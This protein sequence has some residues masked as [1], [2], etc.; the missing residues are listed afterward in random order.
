MVD[1]GEAGLVDSL[2]SE[3][4][5][6]IVGS[7]A[8]ISESGKRADGDSLST[9][10]RALYDKVFTPLRHVSSDIHKL[11]ICPDGFLHLVPFELMMQ[12]D[13]RYAIEDYEIS[14][15]S[16]GRDFLSDSDGRDLSD[17]TAVVVASPDYDSAPDV[18]SVPFSFTAGNSNSLSM[19]GPSDRSE[20]LSVPFDPL[21]GSAAEGE[22]VAKRLSSSPRVAIRQCVSSTA[23]ESFVKAIDPPPEILHLAT[24]GYF[25]RQARWGTAHNESPLL[26]SGL[27]LAGANRVILGNE[28]DGEDG[29]LTALE[30][31]SM[32]LLGTDLVI[33]SCC[34]SGAGTIANGE[35]VFGLRRPFQHAGA[36]SI[37]MSLIDVP[38]KTTA[39]LMDRFYYNWL[40]GKSK[41][42]ALREASLELLRERRA[43][44][45]GGAHP[46]YWGGFIL[47]GDRN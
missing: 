32:N 26:Y 39:K 19:R 4:R 5:Q 30:V 24:H 9:I 42:T 34:Q 46:L 8:A 21:P 37:V 10:A 40:K 22:A 17:N 7:A 6:K 18:L 45:D 13:G 28:A 36:R 29:I 33:L 47:A 2:A 20:C 43:T 11:I 38:D 31:S 27:A 3:F 41:A 25:C 23:S 44:N 12:P 14:Y 35:G 16:S 1:M 15:A